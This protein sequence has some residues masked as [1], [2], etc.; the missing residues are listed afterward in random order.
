MKRSIG[1]KLLLMEEKAGLMKIRAVTI[2]ASR[3]TIQ[4]QNITTTPATILQQT[5][6]KFAIVLIHGD[7][8]PTLTL[9][10][11]RGNQTFTLY[12]HEQ[13]I[14]IVAEEDLKIEATSGSGYSPTVEIA[15]LSW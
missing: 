4:R 7:G 10:V 15:Y 3:A 6:Y 9:T 12:G 14:E 13:A 2:V 1:E 5:H 11:T 8:D